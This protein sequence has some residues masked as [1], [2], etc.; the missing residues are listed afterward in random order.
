MSIHKSEIIHDTENIRIEDSD[1][2]SITDSR[3]VSSENERYAIQHLKMV[4]P[5]VWYADRVWIVPVLP[6]RRS[7]LIAVG[8]L[9]QSC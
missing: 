7:E 4:I 6:Y 8:Q 3:Y 9:K 2:A 5:D 1:D